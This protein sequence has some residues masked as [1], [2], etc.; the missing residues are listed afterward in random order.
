MNLQIVRSPKRI[1]D[2]G[3]P[4]IACLPLL[5][6]AAVAAPVAAQ[7]A[8]M[9]EGGADG[10]TTIIV[11]G[12]SF[13]GDE[14]VSANKD[15]GD[16]LTTPQAISVVEDD[17]I[18]A[19]N[20][21]T[22]AEA[23]NY[24]SGVRSQSFGSDTRIEYYQIRGF[25]NENLYKD[26]LVLTNSGAFLSWATPAEG[27]GRLEVLKGPSSV[28][29]GGGSAGGI[30][31]IVSKQPDG[32]KLAAFEAGA[33]EYGSVYGSA[34][35]GA[36]LS[37]TLA[38]RANALVRRGDTQ[39]EL[40]E[41]NRTF[42]A[43]ALGWTPL[44]GTTLTL[45][46]SY[47]RD[48]S[49][50]PTGF[51]PYSGFVTPL[52]DGR[53]IPVDL[54]VSD[55]SV[56]R[57][58]RDQYEAGYTLEANLSDR[59]R[60]VSNGRYAEIDLI[61][62]GLY[63]QFRGNPV[64]E[65][66]NVFITRGN[67][68]QDANLD[69]V[70]IDNHLDG[71]FATGAVEHTLLG[72]VDYAWSETSS[73]QASG[74]APRLNVFA[75]VYDIALPALGTPRVTAQKLDRTGIYLQDRMTLGGLTGVLSVRHDWI[76]STSTSNGGA[77]T[78]QDDEKTTYRAG[79]SY[80][81]AAGLAPFVS[82]STSFSPVFGIDEASG[83]AYRPET[84]EAWEAG[85]K[86]QAEGFPLL[87]TASLFSIERDGV[88][89]ANPVAGFPRNQSQ[90]GLVRSR[91]GEIEVQAS[92]LETL[93]VTAALTAFDI[94]NLAGDPALI[95]LAPPATLEFAASAFVDYTL[96][97]A[98][99][100][101]G[102]GLGLGVRHTGRSYADTANTLV[103]PAATVFDAALHYDFANFRVAANVSN[104]FDKHYVAA[105]PS[106]GTC[107]A[108]NLRRATISLAYRFGDDQ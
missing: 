8:A 89:V 68:R 79:L 101:P 6:L 80:R 75:P 24:T 57:Y 48:R 100:L 54:F 91:G 17:F 90:G 106:A 99:A 85:V 86:Y 53:H 26:G 65:G 104:L 40:A 33:D 31:N 35:V 30:V 46:G 3:S 58:D 41:D 4:R 28:L 62:A 44:P 2:A 29:Y 108:A 55:P 105:C 73:A 96:P 64:I 92:P 77:P 103:V 1:I 11:T 38:V 18:D 95:G 69:N 94:E 27:I 76:G 10:H 102:F 67:S 50:R 45:R 21:R 23:L 22:V 36:P 56:D 52:P 13:V 70:T 72:G 84:G 12:E 93:N 60:F 20:L 97:D 74:D 25:R 47:T 88:L 87:A 66:E 63:G 37:D 98:S 15:G 32:R 5:S 14:V 49:Q 107:Y 39:V 16:I 83:E 43:L 42:G 59:V 81:T 71:R 9:L 7:T 34:D 19:L 82:Y 61:Y 78:R 51:L